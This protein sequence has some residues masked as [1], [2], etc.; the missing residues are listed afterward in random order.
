MGPNLHLLV[1]EFSRQGPVMPSPD[2]WL[3][4]PSRDEW[5][6]QERPDG[7]N[8]AASLPEEPVQ[9]EGMGGWAAP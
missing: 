8:Q 3:E 7:K 6:V 4:P 9:K 1:E 5:S 2:G